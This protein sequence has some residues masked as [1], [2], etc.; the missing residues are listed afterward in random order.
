MLGPGDSLNVRDASLIAA[1][2]AFLPG[3]I[4]GSLV[5]GTGLSDPGEMGAMAVIGS[6]L[7]L[8]ASRAIRD[9]WY[10]RIHVPG[11]WHWEELDDGIR[12]RWIDP[13]VQMTEQLPIALGFAA[14]WVPAALAF[15]PANDRPGILLASS[16]LAGLVGLVS[17]FAMRER[18]SRQVVLHNRTLDIDGESVVI[19]DPADQ[20]ARSGDVLVLRDSTRTLR[21]Q[22]REELVVRLE[23]RLHAIPPRAGG[24][25]DVPAPLRALQSDGAS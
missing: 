21:L 13:A 12:V 8:L 2:Q 22:A 20:I 9:G 24:P 25:E 16:M 6:V 3:V 23:A 5:L 10:A 17:Y 1:A 7:H 18:G 14:G 15:A 11:P 4:A 19:L